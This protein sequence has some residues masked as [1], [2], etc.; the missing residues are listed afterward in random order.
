MHHLERSVPQRDLASLVDQP[1]GT[2]WCKRVLPGIESLLGDRIDQHVRQV[3]VVL[4][5]PPP[6]H[7]KVLREEARELPPPGQG[8]LLARMN[9]SVREFV[10]APDVI[11]VSVSGDRDHPLA[12][13][14]EPAEHPGQRSDPR[15]RVHDQISLRAADMIEVRADQG[16]HMRFGYQRD[17]I[18]Y[19]PDRKPGARH[20]DTKR[21]HAA[22]VI[23]DGQRRLTCRGVARTGVE[24]V[25]TAGSWPCHAGSRQPRTLAP[26]DGS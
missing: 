10:H 23:E 25:G 24:P 11:V 14:G 15:A 17:A 16:V 21:T 18:S 20:R 19:L 5:L 7:R 1:G 8:F 26:G 2:R 12:G 3:I 9:K 4:H 6:G 22:S 13:F